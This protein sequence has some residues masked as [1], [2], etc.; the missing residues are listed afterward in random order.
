MKSKEQTPI[1][2][3]GNKAIHTYESLSKPK[4]VSL[5]EKCN[6]TRAENLIK[7]HNYVMKM[8][9]KADELLDH[10][11]SY[12][13][14]KD[15]N[16]EEL[17][18]IVNAKVLEALEREW[19]DIKQQPKESG[20]YLVSMV[21]GVDIAMYYKDTN[22]W[23]SVDRPLKNAYGNQVIRETLSPTAWMKLPKQK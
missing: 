4:Q 2:N 3:C 6:D 11:C 22:E 18:S 14:I 13:G 1:C 5:C 17:I 7:G 20:E 16:K 10:Y 19:I 21:G 9:R 8:K 12:N 15:E 23:K